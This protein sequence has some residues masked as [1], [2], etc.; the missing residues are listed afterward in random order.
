M[1]ML[2]DRLGAIPMKDFA[3]KWR[4]I[5][6]KYDVLPPDH[7]TQ[8][9]PLNA[10]SAETIGQFTGD[11]DLHRDFPFR[12]G[13]FRSIESILIDDSHDSHVNPDEVA[14]IRKWLYRRG[15][16]F[17]RNIFLSWNHDCAVVTNWKML[18]KYWSSFYYPASYD[19]TVLDESLE[20]A[21]LFFHEGAIYFGTNHPRYA[22]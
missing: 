21:V 13:F 4:F 17:Q 14:R 18:V 2:H 22:R 3:R 6:P 16:P 5:D 15:I 7:L 19:L 20:W 11:S 9:R 10:Q 8:V 12:D 1:T